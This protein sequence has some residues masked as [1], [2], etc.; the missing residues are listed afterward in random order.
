MSPRRLI[1]HVGLSKSGTTALQSVVASSR[2]EL[3]S[4]G[5]A[6]PLSTRPAVERVLLRPL[7]WRPGSGF[8]APRKP[9]P[10]ARLSVPADR[11][12]A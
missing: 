5:V 9:D 6:V 1:L 10:L 12:G 7:G 4:H 2:S 3:A 8:V 11:G